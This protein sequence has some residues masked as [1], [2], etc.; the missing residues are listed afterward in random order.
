MFDPNDNK[1]YITSEMVNII[2]KDIPDAKIIFVISVTPTGQVF[3]DTA[4]ALP[5][6]VAQ[7]LIIE[8]VAEMADTNHLVATQDQAITIKR[9]ED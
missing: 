2:G 6:E 5:P 3:A 7:N 1:P 4:S 9:S 8:V